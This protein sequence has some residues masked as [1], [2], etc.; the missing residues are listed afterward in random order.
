[1]VKKKKLILAIKRQQQCQ[2]GFSL[3][4]L[5][6]VLSIIAMAAA[7]VIPRLGGTEGRDFRLKTAEAKSVLNHARRLAIVQGRTIK[8]QFF[9]QKKAN[10]DQ[11]LD[12]KTKI[13]QK[14]QKLHWYSQGIDVSFNGNA[15]HEDLAIAITFFPEGGSTG[16]K[17]IFRQG[18]RLRALQIDSLT[19]RMHF[20]E[21]DD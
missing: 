12:K 15:V 7:L 6:V 5:L 20:I 9:F 17:F 18:K 11:S 21:N 8:A 10:V 14:K 19:G 13:K 1:M 4:E 16:G 3:L 2:Q